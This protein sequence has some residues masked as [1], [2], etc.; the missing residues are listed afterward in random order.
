MPRTIECVPNFSEGRRPEVISQIADAI[1]AVP[2]V[3]ILDRE[4]DA[5]HNR[6]VITFIAPPESVVEAALQGARAARDLIDL[7]GH[8]GEHPRMGAMDVCPLI[9]LEGVTSEMCVA[10]ARELGERMAAE[11]EIPVYLYEQ[12]AVRPERADLAAVR[13]GGFE[14]LREAAL[15]DESRRPDFGGPGLHP[16]AGAT[17]VGVR[18]P[19]IAYN[20]DLT[21]RDADIAKKIAAAV[22][23][24]DGGLRC[25]K[26][27]GF[28][29]R[30][31]D[32]AQVSMNLTD[33]GAT[34]LHR[35]FE[36]VKRE[37]ERYGT[38]IRR[39]EIIGLV[40]EQALLDAAAWEL[41]IDGFS[42]SMILERQIAAARQSA[43]DAAK[44][45]APET[46]HRCFVDKL[47]SPEEP[48]VG[49]RAAAKSG[50]LGCALLERIASALHA[51]PDTSEGSGPKTP[52]EP[53]EEGPRTAFQRL[54]NSFQKI[55]RQTDESGADAP[56]KLPFRILALSAEALEGAAEL[57]L[58]CGRAQAADLGIAALE[59]SA[60]L[61]GAA[62]H[63]QI[64][65]GAPGGQPLDSGQRRLLSE[66][67]ARG[68]NAAQ[69]T[70][71]RVRNI[72]QG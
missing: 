70:E 5:S 30:E 7:N 57:A 25:L 8:T 27:L 53:S 14:V 22:R 63:L 61:S 12:A 38:G 71:A 72:M 6:S 66:L 60:C 9:P 45:E 10:L 1:A 51:G 67:A 40:P 11:L 48:A 62:L 59:L 37:A 36:A 29:I 44:E 47:A 49:C 4:S 28:F 58:S 33:F 35:A 54:R 56:T 17:A 2:G 18:K 24:R 31:R 21:T 69:S 3:S 46:P 19:L 39:S 52:A 65:D 42:T 15:T 23:G 32:C 16:T 26:A 68:Q 13:K 64:M 20:I 34:G 43:A 55:A 41:Q 50:A